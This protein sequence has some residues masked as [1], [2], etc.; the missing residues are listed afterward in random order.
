M[1]ELLLGLKLFECN[2][3]FVVYKYS[4]HL[5][6]RLLDTHLSNHILNLQQAM[7]HRHKFE[8]LLNEADQLHPLHSSLILM[9]KLNDHQDDPFRSQNHVQ[10][11]LVHFHLLED[12]L[13][14]LH[15]YLCI[16]PICLRNLL[17]C[18]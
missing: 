2:P 8:F 17:Q 4:M 16:P 15:F 18:D 11:F 7:E 12:F 9:Q 6:F 14:R 5:R 1:K 10:F 13:R 3:E